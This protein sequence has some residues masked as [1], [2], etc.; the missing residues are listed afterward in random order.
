MRK[1]KIGI[2][3]TGVLFIINGAIKMLGYF[4]KDFYC[5]AFQFDL[6]FGMLMSAVGIIIIARR[7][8]VQDM[9]FTIFGVMILADALFKIQIC[10]DAKKFGLQNLWWKIMMIALG[11]GVLG[12]LLLIIPFEGARVM[13]ELAGIAF[14]AEGALNLFVALFTVKILQ[15]GYTE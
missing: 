5:L 6:A 7:D 2:V 4:S 12:C 8:I 13:M 11:T 9:I 10:V 1:C 14:I 3:L 15:V